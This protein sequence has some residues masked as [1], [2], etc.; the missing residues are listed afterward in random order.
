M[1]YITIATLISTISAFTVG[2]FYAL[3][4]WA[5]WLV[6]NMLY[7]LVLQFT[8]GL[9]FPLVMPAKRLLAKCLLSLL[10]SSC[11]ILLTKPLAMACGY[12]IKFIKTVV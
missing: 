4:W 5:A 8:F 12:S 2:M 10:S 11:A 1:N 9:I 7:L 3:K 6:P